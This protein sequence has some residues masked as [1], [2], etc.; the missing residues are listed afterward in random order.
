MR[1]IT[2]TVTVPPGTPAVC[3]SI[4]TF[5]D[6]TLGIQTAPSPPSNSICTDPEKTAAEADLALQNIRGK[7]DPVQ[8]SSSAYLV[9]I[10]NRGG[11]EAKRVT[12]DLTTS[13][14][15]KLADQS[16]VAGGWQASGF[17]CA[18]RPPAGGESS[19]VTCT[20]GIIKSGGNV[21]PAVMV[22]FPDKGIGA[23]HAQVS[24]AGDTTPGN[25]GTALNVQVAPKKT[26]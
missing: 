22:D 4:V 21:N 23:I 13:G 2:K 17:N 8:G 5:T 18:P 10:E 12:V 20:G 6:V 25:S 24:G 19:A 16:A 1:D 7:P 26:G 14:M 9:M 11:G 15:A 3:V